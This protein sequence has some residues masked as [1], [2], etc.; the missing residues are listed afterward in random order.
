MNAVMLLLAVSTFA[1][2]TWMPEP[3]G[4]TALVEDFLKKYYGKMSHTDY[5]LLDRA[6]CTFEWN[7]LGK[8]CQQKI[9]VNRCALHLVDACLEPSEML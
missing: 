2:A 8:T 9:F 6:A 1:R 5:T 4:G 3:S 7:A